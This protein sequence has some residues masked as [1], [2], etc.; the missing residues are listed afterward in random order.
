MMHQQPLDTLLDLAREARDSAG[1]ALANERRT[2]QHTV[3][4]LDALGRYRLEY[5]QRLQDAMHAGIDPATMHNYQ[6]FLASLD[7]AIVRARQALG[8][9]EQRVA[10]SQQHWQQEQRKLSSYDTLAS[11]RADQIRQQAQRHEQRVNDE[12]STNALLRRR[13][14]QDDSH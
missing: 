14:E 6:Q 3:A 4:Q 11:R 8:D 9:Q 7:A 2:Q 1:T 13:R 12:L 10:S 5:A